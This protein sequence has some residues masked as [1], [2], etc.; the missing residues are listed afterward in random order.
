MYEQNRFAGEFSPQ[1]F[2]IFDRPQYN[3]KSRRK[4]G[5]SHL[6]V[7][8]VTVAKGYLGKKYIQ[9][10]KAIVHQEVEPAGNAIRFSVEGGRWY[11]CQ[12]T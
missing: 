5:I 10:T 7:R 4:L 6:P 11:R 2:V 12:I 1:R 3:K 9:R 8:I